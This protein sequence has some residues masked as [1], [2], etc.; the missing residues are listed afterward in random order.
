MISRS[1][2]ATAGVSPV[3]RHYLTSSKGAVKYS[4]Y[5]FESNW[6]FGQVLF[7]SG[8]NRV[9]RPGDTDRDNLY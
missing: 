4:A 7:R 2:F 1:G 6:L 5:E 9:A 3:T 8:S